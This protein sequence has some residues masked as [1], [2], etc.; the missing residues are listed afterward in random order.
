MMDA[1]ASTGP[2]DAAVSSN[3]PEPEAI[4]GPASETLYIQ[5]LNERIKITSALALSTYRGITD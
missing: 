3:V 5:N 4:E 1:V 2:I